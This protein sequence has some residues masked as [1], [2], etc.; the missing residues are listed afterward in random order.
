[1]GLQEVGLQLT[2]EGWVLPLGA[3]GGG[4][5]QLAVVC[6]ILNTAPQCRAGV[7][8]SGRPLS[9]LTLAPLPP[10]KQQ[11][12]PGSAPSEAAALAPT[13]P[14]VGASSTGPMPPQ[15]HELPQPSP[16]AAVQ[17][18]T[19]RPRA[20]PERRSGISGAQPAKSAAFSFQPLTAHACTSKEL[21]LPPSCLQK[22]GFNC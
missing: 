21:M 15:M 6:G 5:R 13:S 20:V 19:P 1:M 8:L 22:S 7:R 12:Q 3:E 2:W 10:P 16:T 4:W 17:R 11:P 14:S 18:V 9:F